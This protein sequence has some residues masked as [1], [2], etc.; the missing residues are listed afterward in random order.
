MS[1]IFNY[2]LRFQNVNLYLEEPAS[3]SVVTDF[4]FLFIENILKQLNYV[5]NST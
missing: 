4:K 2:L 3:K 1:D 5:F